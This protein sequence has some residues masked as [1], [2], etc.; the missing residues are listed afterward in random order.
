MIP[1]FLSK[2]VRR[3]TERTEISIGTDWRA[4]LGV[5]VL[6]IVPY[7]TVTSSVLA[8]TATAVIRGTVQDSSGAVVTG[9]NVV[10]RDQTRNQR[11]EQTTN[12]E[13]FFEFRALPLG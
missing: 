4:R 5:L 11:W 7:L 13:G 8:Q 2:R 10:L 12:E 1:F 6:A 3:P 9:V